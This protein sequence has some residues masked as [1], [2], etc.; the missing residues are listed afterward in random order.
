MG[1]G[2]QERDNHNSRLT[3]G[4]L[5]SRE[6][7]QGELDK[8]SDPLQ[9]TTIGFNFSSFQGNVFRCQNITTNRWCCFLTV[10]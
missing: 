8:L 10:C 7:M 3:E 6:G 4:S 1:P 2:R 5:Y 9:G